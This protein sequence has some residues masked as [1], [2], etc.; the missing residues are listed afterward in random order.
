M[1]NENQSNSYGPLFSDVEENQPLRDAKGQAA[2]D[3]AMCE[4]RIKRQEEVSRKKREAEEK[5][6][7]AAE[8]KE[9]TAEGSRKD[10]EKTGKF[11]TPED[12]VRAEA[13]DIAEPQG[14]ESIEEQKRKADVY[15]DR[16]STGK[17]I[18]EGINLG[19]W[20]KNVTKG[21]PEWRRPND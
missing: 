18:W 10:W 17:K 1:S 3:R 21:P 19:G 7:K 16:H 12:K 13:H 4:V 8:R 6:L 14:Q 20:P 9:E 15:H 2:I 11:K 5:E